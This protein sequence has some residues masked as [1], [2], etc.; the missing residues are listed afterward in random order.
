[1]IYAKIKWK[2]LTSQL[3]ASL[4]EKTGLIMPTI[5]ST[6]NINKYMPKELHNLT[7]YVYKKSKD[8]A[9]N[10]VMNMREGIIYVRRKGEWPSTAI[11]STN[12]LDNLLGLGPAKNGV[13]DQ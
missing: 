3:V 4:V 6:I 12:D 11:F 10:F 7:S 1:M 2:K 8:K 5:P 9:N 13:I